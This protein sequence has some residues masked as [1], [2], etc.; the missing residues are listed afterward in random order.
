MIEMSEIEY[1][2]KELKKPP[3]IKKY[4]K[5]PAKIVLEDFMSKNIKIAQITFKDIETKKKIA[6]GIG[7][8]IAKDTEGKYKGIVE[9]LGTEENSIFLRRIKES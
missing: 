9:L 3:K 8:I 5:S 7:L 2:I 4:T 1:E 6:R